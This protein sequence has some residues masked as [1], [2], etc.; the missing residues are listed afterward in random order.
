MNDNGLR[1]V[2]ADFMKNCGWVSRG[3]YYHFRKPF[4]YNLLW[5]KAGELT[6]IRVFAGVLSRLRSAEREDKKKAEWGR[7]DLNSGHKQFGSPF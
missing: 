5:Q 6:D 4:G 7:R 1:Q 3:S 2:L